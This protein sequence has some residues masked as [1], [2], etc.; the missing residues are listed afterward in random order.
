MKSAL[1]F[2][3]RSKVEQGNNEEDWEGAEGKEDF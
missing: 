1:G 3:L 2:V